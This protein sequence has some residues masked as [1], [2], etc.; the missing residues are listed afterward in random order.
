MRYGYPETQIV[1][2]LTEY[3]STMNEVDIEDPCLLNSHRGEP[4]SI[5]FIISVGAAL[6][7]VKQSTYELS[8]RYFIPVDQEYSS[9]ARSFASLLGQPLLSL[10]KHVASAVPRVR[11]LVIAT[12]CLSKGDISSLPPSPLSS[13]I[14]AADTSTMW[15][16]VHDWITNGV[17]EPAIMPKTAHDAVQT[18]GEAVRFLRQLC[19]CSTP[20]PAV[21]DRLDLPTLDGAGL[22]PSRMTRVEREATAAAVEWLTD[23]V[24][25]IRHSISLFALESVAWARAF[26][27]FRLSHVKSDPLTVKR[28][29]MDIAEQHHP[30]VAPSLD[31]ILDHTDM[32]ASAPETPVIW[33]PANPPLFTN[34][35]R[36]IGDSLT[37]ML[38]TMA[39]RWDTL[40]QLSGIIDEFR[41]LGRLYRDFSFPRHMASLRN[42]AVVL[43]CVLQHASE[44]DRPDVLTQVVRYAVDGQRG[45]GLIEAACI[46]RAARTDALV[47]VDGVYAPVFSAASDLLTSIII[48]I[49]TLT[50]VDYH[51]HDRKFRAAGWQAAPVDMD[52]I[53]RTDAA[54]VDAVREGWGAFQAAAM[55]AYGTLPVDGLEEWAGA[56]LGTRTG[57]V[58]IV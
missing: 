37:G 32:T 52:S 50:I 12:K 57:L 35:S 24:P 55:T 8:E 34:L 48:H 16:A 2:L 56:V 43:E 11:D 15:D 45:V 21:P 29:F 26:A 36:R 4:K 7:S 42:V 27:K 18:A 17:S 58:K 9:I 38:A 14:V 54:L 23:A 31:M 44:V 53:R 39:G 25:V 20:L 40:L 6:R 49:K 1:R 46:A 28:V 47:G 3:I 51:D 13:A 19:A 41:R 33:I 22:L 30:S 10:F 5:K